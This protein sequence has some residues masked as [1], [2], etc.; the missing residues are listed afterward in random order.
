MYFFLYYFMVQCF[1]NKMNEPYFAFN[2][3]V[4]GCKRVVLVVFLKALKN[5]GLGKRAQIATPIGLI[6][7]DC[8]E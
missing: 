8:F 2:I 4:N 6:G 7:V 3:V 5:D 1:L